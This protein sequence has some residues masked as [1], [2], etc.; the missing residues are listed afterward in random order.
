M[1]R[2]ERAIER[3]RIEKILTEG[4]WGTLSLN[5]KDGYPYGVPLNYVYAAG[6]ILIHC[7]LEGDKIE[8]IRRDNRVSFCVVGKANPL[9]DKFSTDYASAIV[10]GRAHLVADEEKLDILLALV[11]KYSPEYKEQG[12]ALALGKLSKVLCLRIEIESVTGKARK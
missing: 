10:F 3:A 12:R 8:R 7:A 11:D 1:I 5:G 4:L 9:P 6:S 2:K